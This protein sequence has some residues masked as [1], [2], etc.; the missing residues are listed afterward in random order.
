M[1]QST[2]E[3]QEIPKEEA[4]VLPVGEPRKR[5]RVCSLAAERRQKRKERTRRNRGSRRES[6]AACR[7][8]Y[9]R[10]KVAWRKRKLVR[11]IGTQENCGP[12][13][14]FSPTGIRMTHRAK[15]A[16]RKG[17]IVRNK[18][19]RAKAELGIQKV[20][21][22][23]EGRK[24]VK[25]QGGGRPR[26]LRKRNLK[27]L[28]LESTGNLDTTFSKTTRLE[29]AKRISRCTVGMRKIRNW[30]LW[31]GRP[32]QKRKKKRPVEREAVI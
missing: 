25:D 22:R 1:M 14:E 23:H 12:R 18:W 10:A 27:K 19:T 4:A 5:R 32:P 2:E 24:R 26:Y 7:K 31:R 11:R 6:A 9:R 3:H 28:R 8:V 13:K 16:R 21:T 20:R 29:I 17:N 15:V 30:T